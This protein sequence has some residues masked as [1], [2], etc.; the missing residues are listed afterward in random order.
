M[1]DEP[2]EDGRLLD[3]EVV[4]ARILPA[5]DNGDI[6]DEPVEEDDGETPPFG[7][8]PGASGDC[9]RRRMFCSC[10]AAS[11]FLSSRLSGPVPL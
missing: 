2:A 1:A 4:G 7:A 10:S 9:V 5:D 11:L 8:V 3:D 6:R